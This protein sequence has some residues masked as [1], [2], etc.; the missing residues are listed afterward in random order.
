MR[1]WRLAAA[2]GPMLAVGAVMAGCSGG[3]GSATPETRPATTTT[4]EPKVT[5]V[6]VDL[7]VSGDRVA[8]V[9]G[10]KGTC[11]I[12]RFGAPSYEFT[13]VSYPDLGTDG[14]LKVF[15]PVVVGE[16]VGL[17]ATAQVTIGD[18]GLVSP[19]SGTGITVSENMR[20]VT[21]DA[22]LRGGPGGAEDIN[23]ASP[24]NSLSG[25]ITGTIR[26][27]TS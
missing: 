1:T 7:L 13:G 26:C 12:P 2:I 22:A 18:V 27:T 10:T 8:A 24:D 20:V 21:I 9:K 23:L 17:P 19:S 11:N 5:R 4:T 25:R 16:T 3:D 6:E 14:S 15:G